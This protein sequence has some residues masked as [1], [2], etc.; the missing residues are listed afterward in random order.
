MSLMDNALADAVIDDFDNLWLEDIAT[1][2]SFWL[3]P[4]TARDDEGNK[5][6]IEQLIQEYAVK[7]SNGDDES[8]TIDASTGTDDNMMDEDELLAILADMAPL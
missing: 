1:P 7:E 5:V 2:G 6:N 8:E 4:P 3:N